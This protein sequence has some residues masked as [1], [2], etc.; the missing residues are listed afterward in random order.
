VLRAIE[1][2]GVVGQRPYQIRIKASIVRNGD[3][4]VYWALS[5][6]WCEQR[7]NGVDRIG[8]AEN[9]RDH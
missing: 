2:A 8:A 7:T 3:A 9:N 6:R 1:F 4:A 5:L